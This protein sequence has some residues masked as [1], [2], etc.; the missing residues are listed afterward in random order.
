MRP[1]GFPVLGFSGSS[2]TVVR[3][4]FALKCSTHTSE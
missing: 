3:L 2:S 1:D 4:R